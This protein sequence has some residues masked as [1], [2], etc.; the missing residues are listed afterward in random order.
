MDN[1]FGEEFEP[2]V[3]EQK[4]SVN[5]AAPKGKKV[6]AVPVKSKLDI[7]LPARNIQVKMYN[8][9][10]LYDTPE[11]LEKPTLDHVRKWMVEQNGFTE[12]MDKDR[13]GLML[14]TP[15]EEGQDPFVYCG[16]KFEKQG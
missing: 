15:T 7:E 13:A 10:Y 9:F 1:L 8:D 6:P 12:L 16:V 5:C 14:V 2:P 4:C 3:L 11:N